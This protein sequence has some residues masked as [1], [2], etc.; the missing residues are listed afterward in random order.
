[1]FGTAETLAVGNRTRS[2]TVV[3]VGESA[4]LPLVGDGGNCL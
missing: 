1:M 3:P 2:D 4:V